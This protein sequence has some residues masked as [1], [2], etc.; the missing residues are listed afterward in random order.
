MKLQAELNNEKHNVEIRRDG[1]RFFAVVDDRTYELEASEP[2]PNV[3]LLKH[4]GKIYEIYISPVVSGTSHVRIGSNE[5]DITIHD[6]KRLRS[7]GS[8]HEQG[9]GMAEIKT[10][11]PGKVVRLL[12][13]S[14]TEVK[15][16]DGVVIVEAM[17]MQNEM[18]SPKDGVVKEIRASEGSTVNAGEI[19]AI[20]E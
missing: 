5:F 9:E 13:E 2:E 6:P 7:S 11:M 16:G 18:R 15:K 3:F 19:L 10:A 17:K 12:V 4:E 14:G 8:G 20:I 1:D